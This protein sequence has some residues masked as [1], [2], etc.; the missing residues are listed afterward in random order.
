MSNNIFANSN[1]TTTTF[2]F[3]KQYTIEEFKKQICEN[4]NAKLEVKPNFKTGKLFFTYSVKNGPSR[5]G[6]VTTKGSGNEVETEG[7]N[8]DT[9][10]IVKIKYH[11]IVNPIISELDELDRNGNPVYMIHEAGQTAEAIQV[12]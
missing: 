11:N 2:N 7:V 9:G 8:K 3:V 5:T 10:E 4:K 6:K 1:E 12:F